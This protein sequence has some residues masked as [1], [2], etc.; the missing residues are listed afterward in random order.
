MATVKEGE[1]LYTKAEIAKTKKAH[2]LIKNSG[3]PSI[4]ELIKIV[5]DGNILTYQEK[6]AQISRERMKF[7]VCLWNM[8]EAI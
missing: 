4:N 7:M 3:Y 2:E 8:F 1:A 5:E 6:I